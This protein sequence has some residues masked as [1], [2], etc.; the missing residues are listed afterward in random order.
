MTVYFMEECIMKE[1]QLIVKLKRPKGDDG[2]K[3][4]SI[5][6][7]EDIVHRIDVIAG[8]TGRSRNELISMFMEYALDRCVV[9]ND[10]TDQG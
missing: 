1:D 5:R 6:V 4:F 9:E 8:H 7:R 10:P 2:Y 3:T